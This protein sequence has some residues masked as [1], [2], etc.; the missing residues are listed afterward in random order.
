MASSFRAGTITRP[1]TKSRM[2]QKSSSRHLSKVLRL[3]YFRSF[4]KGTRDA[5]FVTVS[6]ISKASRSNL[7][8]AAIKKRPLILTTQYLNQQDMTK[9]AS[10]R[11]ATGRNKTITIRISD[12]AADILKD[13]HNK[14]ELIDKLIIYYAE[15]LKI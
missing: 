5:S 8:K 1:A 3:I 13:V 4:R 12:R 10:G 11:P 14:S 15:H 6:L 7:N 2:R 9:F